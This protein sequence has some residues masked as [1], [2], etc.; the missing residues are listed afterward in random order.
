MSI[1]LIK[2]EIKTDKVICQ[3]YS[4]TM[5]ESDIIVPDVNPDIKKIL[6]ISGN[7][8]ITQK[9]IQPDKVLLQGNVHMTVLYVPDSTDSGKIKSLSASREFS[10]T[11]DCRGVTP[12][13]QLTA[14]IASLSFDSTLINSRKLSLR[15]TP[16]INVKVSTAV[17]LPISTDIEDN[18]NIALKKE[19]LRLIS[20][21]GAAESQIILRHQL[22]LSAGKPPI[23]EILRVNAVP[24]STELCIMDGKAVAKGQIKICM[25]Y[26]ADT[27]D[28]E[29]QFME[30]L[31]PFTEILDIDGI[32][33][34]MEGEIDY[35]VNDMYYEIRDDSDGE[36]RNLGIELVL[37]A[38]VKGSEL[39]DIDAI[40]DA[41]SLSNALDSTIKTYHVEQLLD[42]STAEITHKD[43]AKLP[44]MLPPLRQVCDV[45]SNVNID[46]ITA[47]N[48]H[49]IVYGTIHTNI[50]YL[51]DDE[52]TPVS[53]FNHNTEFSHDFTVLGVGTDTACDAGAFME[54]VSYTLSGGD[55][56]ELRF[57]LGLSVKSLKTG[58]ISIVDELSEYTPE[59]CDELPCIVIYFVQKGDTLWNIA[60]RYR[61]TVDS[62][63]ALNNLDSD[64]IYPGQRI[65][66][67]SADII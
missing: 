20:E 53:E 30:Y 61:T 42:N 50:L 46:R 2:E 52:N 67:T 47:E 51:S 40:T 7:A 23:G 14:E 34:G 54:D 35:N 26:S 22:E 49:I 63:K 59:S 29:I 56:L 28:E 58:D 45:S 3:K 64:T 31:L 4:Q 1:N 41:Y 24:Y 13:M 66:I 6:E 21:T 44:Q 33:E 8:C 17:I 27:P 9:M 43:Q 48:N 19:S 32:T 65:K 11:I 37:N 36:P 5:I 55:S 10:H 57:V 25:L 15:C 38:A 39:Y 60:K 16:G 62:I 18:G 12:E